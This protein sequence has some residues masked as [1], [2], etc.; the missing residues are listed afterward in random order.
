VINVIAFDAD[1]TLWHNEILYQEAQERL[2]GLLAGYDHT[3]SVV[4]ELYKTEISNLPLYG[5][6]LKSFGLSMI[7]TAVRLSNGAVDGQTVQAIIDIA[8]GMKRAPVQLL[9][10]VVEVIEA[11]A[12]DHMLMVIT[13]GDLLDQETKVQHSGLAPH[14]SHIEV[15][16]AKTVAVYRAVLGRHQI[17]PCEFLMVGNSPRSDI[18]PIVEL[19]ALAVHIPY[20]VTWVHEQVAAAQEEETPAGYLQLDHIGQLPALIEQLQEERGH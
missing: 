5:Y 17:E 14:F 3:T 8:K 2:A 19:G 13:K 11:L 7:E 6:G 20:H 9:D 10:G 15:V 4:D 12:R 16:S 18:L 1:D